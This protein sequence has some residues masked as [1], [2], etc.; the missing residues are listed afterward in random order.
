MFCLLEVYSILFHVDFFT[1]KEIKFPNKLK[2]EIIP[3]ITSC[4]I[5]KIYLI[6]Y[7]YQRTFQCYVKV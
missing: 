1:F 6:N 5:Q 2:V 3:D 7:L 4:L